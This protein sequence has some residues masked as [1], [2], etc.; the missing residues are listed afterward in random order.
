[1]L[2]LFRSK[3]FCCSGDRFLKRFA[4]VICSGVD[5]AGN[6]NAL[7]LLFESS[8]C[9][10]QDPQAPEPAPGNLPNVFLIPPKN[11]IKLY[12]QNITYSHAVIRSIPI[13]LLSI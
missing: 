1:M 12:L 5:L 9:S 13:Q 2:G 3:S 11:P 8:P 6:P 10:A 7:A 4:V